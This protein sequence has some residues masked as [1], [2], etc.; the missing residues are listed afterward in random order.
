MPKQNWRLIA[1]SVFMEEMLA[2]E[3]CNWFDVV[4]AIVSAN[5]HIAFTSTV[6]KSIFTI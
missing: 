6:H 5:V 3:K 4:V 1:K 2:S